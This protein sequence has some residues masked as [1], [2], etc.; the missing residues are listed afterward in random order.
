KTDQGIRVD[1]STIISKAKFEFKAE[2]AGAVAEVMWERLRYPGADT[3]DNK[4]NS[5][6]QN[7]KPDTPRPF[8]LNPRKWFVETLKALNTLSETGIEPSAKASTEIKKWWQDIQ[9]QLVKAD[10]ELL[11]KNRKEDAAK[12]KGK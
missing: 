5:A 7:N 6:I 9:P 1:M 8:P 4:P 3:G 10:R 12:G 2:L 11:E